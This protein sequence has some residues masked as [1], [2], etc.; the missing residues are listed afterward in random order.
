MVLDALAAEVWQSIYF[1]S[2]EEMIQCIE[3]IFSDQESLVEQIVN[4]L[5]HDYDSTITAG[6]RDV[7]LN[8]RLRTPDTFLLWDWMGMCVKSSLFLSV[9][10][11]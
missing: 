2:L 4:R 8:L 5:H 7:G 6:Y 10:L 3:V 9:S 1:K 11:K